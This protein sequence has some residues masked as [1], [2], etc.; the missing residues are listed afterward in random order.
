V[1]TIR[2]TKG[3]VIPTPAQTDLPELEN[4]VRFW[5]DLL[6]NPELLEK[7]VF[8]N[9]AAYSEIRTLEGKPNRLT[10]KMELTAADFWKG[11]RLTE[12]YKVA[13][14]VGGQRKAGTEQMFREPLLSLAL[15]ELGS[16]PND[17]PNLRAV[18]SLWATE[19]DVDIWWGDDV[20]DLY[21]NADKTV[22]EHGIL[23][24]AFGY[25]EDCIR[26][27]YPGPWWKR[28]PRC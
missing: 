26:R 20:L 2:M 4:Q 10:G 28:F 18:A 9:E 12:S 14:P 21:N 13:I 3:I 16:R 23:G 25:R 22:E 1:T 15:K 5:T 17:F 6:A 24:R 19:G 11:E 7:T 8:F 27:N